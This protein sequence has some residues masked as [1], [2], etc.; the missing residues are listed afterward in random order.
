MV[1]PVNYST[2]PETVNFMKQMPGTTYILKRC[3]EDLLILNF[4]CW[5]P[6]HG[7]ITTQVISD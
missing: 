4:H 2:I 1:V 6:V 5:S 3:A 7:A